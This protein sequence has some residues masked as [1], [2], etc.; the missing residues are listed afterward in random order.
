M[1]LKKLFNIETKKEPNKQEPLKGNPL[2]GL[3]D[4]IHVK[5]IEKYSV[6]ESIIYFHFPGYERDI[7]CLNKIEDEFT[8]D[9]IIKPHCIHSY[10]GDKVEMYSQYN[11][12]FQ[13]GLMSNNTTS[14][15]TFGA[16]QKE[17][18]FNINDRVSVL[19]DD[20]EILE[21][22]I[23]EKGYRVGKDNDG[24]IIEA[25]TSITFEQIEK[26]AKS[27]MK[28]WRYVDEKNGKSYTNYVELSQKQRI[29]EMCKMQLLGILSFQKK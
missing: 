9:I 20:N 14:Y 27:E 18:K 3:E 24:V 8:K 12:I 23:S 2:E 7:F 29:I 15:I 17:I 1:W 22:N 5:L 28:K 4:E 26:M 13:I 6:S 11:T 16:Y 19:F 25:K 21:F 10:N